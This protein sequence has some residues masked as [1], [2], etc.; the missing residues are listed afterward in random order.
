MRRNTAK[1]AATLATAIAWAF[2]AMACG[3]PAFRVE[4]RE[5]E[6]EIRHWFPRRNEIW[7]ELAAGA[8]DDAQP[9]S[10]ARGARR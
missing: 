5:G 2:T 8:H 3:R 6:F 4:R 1:V 7:I 10:D 9:A